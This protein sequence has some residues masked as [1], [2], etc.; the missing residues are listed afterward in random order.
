MRNG[1]FVMRTAE[2]TRK[3]AETD[4]ALVLNID[5][6][7]QHSINSGVG[8]FDH[9]LELFSRHGSFDLDVKCKGDIH[10]DGHHTIEDIG[11]CLGKAFAL[12][13]GEG[14][15][16]YR[17][18]DITLPMDEALVLCAID[19]SGRGSLGFNVKLPDSALGGMDSE[20][21]EEFLIAFVRNAGITVH[22]RMLEGSN[23]HHII[24]ACFKALARALR[25]AV[26]IDES[27]KDEIPSTKGSLT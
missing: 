14:R 1:D 9:M 13:I 12:C 2:V 17:Y 15:G 19:I 4:I 27:K 26:K 18:S 23:T 6:T 20:L 24:E 25:A 21:L 3:T 8:F 7:G 22:I 11:I 10:V 16:I 5:G